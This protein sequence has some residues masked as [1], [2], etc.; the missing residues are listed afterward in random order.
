MIGC[1][2]GAP[3]GADPG[4]S[5]TD[6]EQVRQLQGELVEAYIHHDVAVLERAL[7]DD[8]TF[9]NDRGEVETKEQVLSNFRAGG[10]RTISS[11]EIHNPVVRVYGDAAVMIYGYTSKEQYRGQDDSGSYR[12][13]R[14]FVR[15]NGRWR[16]V[17]GQETRLA[18]K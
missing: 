16:I 15:M 2:G 11:Y 18:E 5:A 4:A 13:T 10:D 6:A 3:G 17:A 7:A 14:V 1:L 12:I 8:Y 9:T